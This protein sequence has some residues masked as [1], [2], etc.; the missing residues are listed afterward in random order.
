MNSSTYKTRVGF[1]L[2]IFLDS[3]L[4]LVLLIISIFDRVFSAEPVILFLIFVLALC[5]FL[6]SARSKITIEDE[7]I[8]IRKLFRVKQLRWEDITNVD[9]MALHKKVYLLLTTTRGFHTVAN[10]HEDFT[11]LV[12]DVVRYVDQE[13]VEEG[14]QDVIEHPVKRISDIVSAWV[15]FIILLGA[16][17]LKII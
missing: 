16:I 5:I 8:G 4:L 13:K 7:G 9:V 11:S 3:L 17:V 12:K 6:K 10:S 2:P 1:L 15:A 14:V